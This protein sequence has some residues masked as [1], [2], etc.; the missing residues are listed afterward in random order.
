MYGCRKMRLNKYIAQAG[1][2]SRRKADKLIKDG[3]VRIDK[4]L[5]VEPWYQIKGDQDVRLNGKPLKEKEFFYLIL[6]KPIGVVT[7]L[8]DRF[9][10][11]TIL[12]CLPSKFKGVFPVGRLDKDSEGLLVLTNDGD[13]CYRTTH[14]K[15]RV[16]KEY[17]IEVKG[18]LKPADLK[19][20]QSGIKDETDVL[21]VK[22]ALIETKLKGITRLRAIVVEGKKRHLR[23]LFARLGFPVV[24]LKRVRIAGLTL[25]NLKPGRC[26]ILSREFLYDKL[27]IMPKRRKKK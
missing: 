25:G 14:P 26:R 10:S 24:S 22:K 23:R 12:D 4:R 20:A 15:F 5:V 6:N 1:M 18:E 21:K 13:L 3:K 19:K 17:L 9:A 7:T 27:A 11:S 2:V 16:E 8:K